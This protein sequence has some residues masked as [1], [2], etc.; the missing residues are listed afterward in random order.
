MTSIFLVL[1]SEP[2]RPADTGKSGGGSQVLTHG[3]P[4]D[5]KQKASVAWVSD[6][7]AGAFDF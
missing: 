6:H 1:I 5:E 4:W 2:R 3:V 7:A